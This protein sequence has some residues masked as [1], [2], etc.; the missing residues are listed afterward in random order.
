MNKVLWIAIIILFAAAADAKGVRV[1]GYFRKNGTY[2]APHMR[3]SPN[4]YKY[5]NY[6]SSG[7]YNP[8][9]GKVGTSNPLGY[10]TRRANPLGRRR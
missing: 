10:T 1:K 7:N 3:S 6:S 5:D 8:Y 4:H 9:T 2:V